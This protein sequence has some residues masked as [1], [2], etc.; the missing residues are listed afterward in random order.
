LYSR[1]SFQEREKAQLDK[2]METKALAKPHLQSR[3]S[4]LML[5]EEAKSEISKD[6]SLE[7]K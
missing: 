5:I 3:D 7:K 6:K 2:E 4:M 1:H